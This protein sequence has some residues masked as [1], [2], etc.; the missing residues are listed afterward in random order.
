MTSRWFRSNSL[1]LLALAV[2]FGCASPHRADQ[3][4]L[5]GGLLGAGTGALIGSTSGNAGAGGDRCRTWRHHRR[6]RRIGIGR[7]RGPESR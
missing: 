2:S 5:V 3:G 4:A 6:G 1:I 7:D